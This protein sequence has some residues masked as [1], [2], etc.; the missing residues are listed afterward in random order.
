MSRTRLAFGS[1]LI[2]AAGSHGWAMARFP[3]DSPLP[4]GIVNSVVRVAGGGLGSGTVIDRHNDPTG[5]G[6]WLCVLTADHVVAESFSWSIGLGDAPGTS[7][8]AQYRFRG[9]VGSGGLRADIA[10]L[11]VHVP[12]MSSLPLLEIA[13]VDHPFDIPSGITQAGFGDQGAIGA[14]RQYDVVSVYGQYRS[15]KNMIDS[16]PSFAWDIYQFTSLQGDLDF[17]PSTGWPPESGESHPLFGDSGG[18]SLQK[19]PETQL[20]ELVGVHS[21]IEATGSVVPEGTRWWDV[22]AGTYQ[23]WIASQCALVPE[24]GTIAVIGLGIA[25]LASRRRRR[26]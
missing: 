11:G 20:W 25:F 13:P 3:I 2:I 23:T 4:V 22:R 1:L 9:P 10:V 17:S 24:P 15:G 12:N 7:Y 26:A 5:T 16:S 6:G 18:P 21:A 19:D 14:P 8:D